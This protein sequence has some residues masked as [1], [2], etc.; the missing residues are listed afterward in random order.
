MRR[1][2]LARLR[3]WASELLLVFLGAYAAFWLTNHQEHLQEAHRR[4]Q[5]LA[6]LEREATTELASAKLQRD[7]QAQIAS[8]FKRALDAGEMP[9]L[10]P[11]FFNSDYSATDV[12]TLLQS[13]GYQLLDVNTL[14]ALRELEGV[15][16]GGVNT[17]QHA[18]QLSDAL[19]VPN[20]D[21]DITFFYDPATKQLRKRFA[22]YVDALESF[23]TFFA[24]YIEAQTRMLAQIRLERAKR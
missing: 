15:L 17:M 13:G 4:D 7:R 6:A 18:Q 22:R 8:E 20:L 2:L 1:P 24:D 19:I 9:P 11:F 5:I 3:R 21:Q 23:Q 10:K 12:A 16:R 14:V